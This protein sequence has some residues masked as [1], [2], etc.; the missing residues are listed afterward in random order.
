MGPLNVKYYEVDIVKTGKVSKHTSTTRDKKYARG[1]VYLPD[2]SFT[3]RRYQLMKID[4]IDYETIH[5]SHLKGTGSLIF[6]G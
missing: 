6:I 4:R 1:K 2:D 5:V 3:G